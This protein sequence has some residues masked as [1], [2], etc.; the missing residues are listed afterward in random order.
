[1][2][3]RSW[4]CEPNVELL[5][6][7]LR[8]DAITDL[9]LGIV[10]TWMSRHFANEV[11]R[12]TSA[13][14][15]CKRNPL[16]APIQQRT[17]VLNHNWESL[18]LVK[19]MRQVQQLL[20][21]TTPCWVIPNNLQARSWQPLIAWGLAPT[22]PCGLDKKHYLDIHQNHQS[23][24]ELCES[25]RE[26][27]RHKYLGHPKSRKKELSHLFPHGMFSCKMRAVAHSISL[28]TGGVYQQ[29]ERVSCLLR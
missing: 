16:G 12:K 29:L 14:G 24:E 7:P 11:R 20:L 8:T 15:R 2:P 18:I 27:N 28:Q 19:T 9:K 23:S 17:A 4:L 21:Q 3:L 6:N 1:M 26:G 5:W 22:F 13:R 10:K 25:G